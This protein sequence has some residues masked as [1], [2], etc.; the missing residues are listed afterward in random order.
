VTDIEATLFWLRLVQLLIAIPL[1]ALA[2][3]G[4]VQVLARMMGQPPGQNFFYRLLRIVASPVVVPCRWITPKSIADRHVPFAAF[5]LLAV[6]YFWVML[7]IA[8]LCIDAGLPIG[9]CLQGR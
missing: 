6:G 2:G 5:A 7:A 9:Q 8:N 1:L 3:A 4:A